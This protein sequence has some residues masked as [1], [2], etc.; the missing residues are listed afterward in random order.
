MIFEVDEALRKLL[1]KEIPIRKNE[2]D[3]A[4]EMPKREWSSRV[5]KPTINLFLYDIVENVELRGSEQ[6]ERID[7]EDG[8]VS[9][10]RNPV[11]MNLFY[12]V[13]GWAKEIQDEHKL[14]SSVLITM[15]RQAFL[16][17]SYL[18]KELQDQPVP[19]RLEVAS[20]I[21]TDQRISELWNKMD[22][23]LHPAIRL[24]VTLSVNPY[25]IQTYTRVSGT[26]LRF[27]QNPDNQNSSSKKDGQDGKDLQATM[28]KT[29]YSVTGTVKSQKY[30]PSAIQMVVQETGHLVPIEED[31]TFNI[32]RL[33][34]GVYHLDLTVNERV[35]KHQKIEVPSPT[36][37]INV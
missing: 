35:L 2:I 11:R 6:W 9:L 18:P 21:K 26:E 10:K 19:I 34:Q 12:L 32:R 33:N 27:K 16:P 28:S 15:L 7:N 24:T 13:T 1:E 29:Y 4:F 36:Y 17:E 3:I 23:D 20:N 25:K 22:N 8:T 30:S 37:E 14:L 5:N 31:G